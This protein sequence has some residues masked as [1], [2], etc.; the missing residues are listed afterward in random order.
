MR[1]LSLILYVLALIQSC[2]I[3]PPQ[4]GLGEPIPWERLEGWHA[5]RHAQAWPA[6][7]NSC[8][9]LANQARWRAVCRAADAAG[10]PADREA[11]IFFETHF[12]PYPV[13]GDKGRREGLITG[14][15][16]PLL[17]G[18]LEPGGRYR[19]PLYGP[20][21]DLVTLDLGGAYPELA[22]RQLRGR[23]VSGIVRPY[24][25]RAQLGAAPGILAGAELLWVDD[26]IDAFFLHIQGSGR[27]RLPDGGTLAVGFADHNGRPYR[28]IGRRLIDTGE[29][30]RED[31][32]LFS[33]RRWLRTNPERV[34]SLL[35][36]NPRYVFFRLRSDA[37]KGPEGAL[38]VPLTAG[39]SLAI[40]KEKLPLGAPVWLETTTPGQPGRPLN[41]L[42][43]AQ[44]TGGAIRGHNRADVF[45]GSGEEAER[46]AGLMKQKGRIFVL[47]PR[48][49]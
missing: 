42:M 11:R 48:S 33:I 20:P 24:P 39:R 6:L 9:R 38:N 41:R 40:D 26:P 10:D 12:R 14:Y 5:D 29:L 2:T 35:H 32:N 34:E 43:M 3:A 25:D 28:S 45:W 47:L 46:M 1:R 27:V 7:L 44:D 36:H 22:G 17:H 30:D 21:G 49:E 15:Y 4:P 37:A 13:Y 19:Y 8:T 23:L 18:S 16:E 31:V